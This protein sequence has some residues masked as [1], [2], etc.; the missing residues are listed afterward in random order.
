MAHMGVGAAQG[1]EKAAEAARAAISSPLLETSISGARGILV[2]VT[3]SPDIGL[4]EMDVATSMITSEASP[5]ATII[6]GAII[7]EEL[8]DEMQ[9][10]VIATGFVE[11]EKDSLSAPEPAKPSLSEIVTKKETPVEPEHKGDSRLDDIFLL[12]RNKR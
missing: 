2:N 11:E 4:E 5:D 9:I 7:N 6:W 10:T 12:N 3:C 8:E 1:K